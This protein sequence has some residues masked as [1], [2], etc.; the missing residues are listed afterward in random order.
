MEKELKF[1]LG[2][3]FVLF[4]FIWIITSMITLLCTYQSNPWIF[5]IT[6]AQYFIFGGILALILNIRRGNFAPWVCLIPLLGIGTVLYVLNW[7]YE[8]IDKEIINEIA[9]PYAV[10]LFFVLCGIAL[11]LGTITRAAQEKKCTVL[12]RAICTGID[13]HKTAHSAGDTAYNIKCP[14]FTFVYNGKTYS[15]NSGTYSGGVTTVVGQ[16]YDLY[17]NPDNPQLF[18][19]K[20]ESKRLKTLDF[21]YGPIFM[22]LGILVFLVVTFT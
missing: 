17:I 9:L 22:A 6:I 13:V 8:F 14:I 2:K 21:F 7:H 18:K 20:S 3:V 4:V 10:S 1:N 5:G 12:V 15:V 11:L 16:E 19:E